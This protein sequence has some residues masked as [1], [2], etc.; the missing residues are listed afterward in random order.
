MRV[1]INKP[2]KRSIDAAKTTAT[3]TFG[4]LTSRF[5]PDVEH[6][7]ARLFLHGVSRRVIVQG[8]MKEHEEL[9]EHLATAVFDKNDINALLV[10]LFTTQSP[11]AMERLIESAKKKAA[12]QK[13][14]R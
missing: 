2:R 11:R 10:T 14:P 9:G 5:R 8:T 7:V 12:K 13:R 4:A 6:G 1:T 3:S